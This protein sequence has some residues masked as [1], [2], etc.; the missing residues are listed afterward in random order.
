MIPRCL[1]H[2]L[3]RGRGDPI[4]PGRFFV[5][6]KVMSTVQFPGVT[7]AL[8]LHGRG[9]HRRAQPGQVIHDSRLPCGATP[10]SSPLR[11]GMPLGVGCGEWAA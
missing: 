10:F 3:E 4:R 8:R 5:L 6:E 1:E 7:Q 11:K 9:L 2:T